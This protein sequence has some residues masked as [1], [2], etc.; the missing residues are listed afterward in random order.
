[1][2]DGT[3]PTPPVETDLTETT[4]S[5]HLA[6]RTRRTGLRILLH[7]GGAASLPH[8]SL[9]RTTSGIASATMPC[10]SL[11]GKMSQH[12]LRRPPD[13]RVPIRLN[14]IQPETQGGGQVV[15]GFPRHCR[16]GHCPLADLVECLGGHCIMGMEQLHDESAIPS[17]IHRVWN[18]EEHAKSKASQA[19]SGA[20]G[21]GR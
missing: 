4:V 2:H 12:H 14:S 1:M 18:T 19:L 10:V 5:L 3:M 21:L 11:F 13:S 15:A 9:L 20:R 17:L 6:H 8:S 16:L 7:S